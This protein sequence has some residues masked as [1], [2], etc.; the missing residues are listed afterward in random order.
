MR[1]EVLAHHKGGGRDVGEEV[2]GHASAG[3]DGRSQPGKA[4]AAATADWVGTGIVAYDHTAVQQVPKAL[5]QVT[6]EPL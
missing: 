2:D 1:G 6:T 3:E 4:L 5:L